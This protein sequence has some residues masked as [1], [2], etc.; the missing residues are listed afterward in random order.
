MEKKMYVKESEKANYKETP[1]S[2]LVYTGKHDENGEKLYE[3]WGTTRFFN[4]EKL[5]KLEED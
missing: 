2:F 4:G 1:S 5:V 3:W